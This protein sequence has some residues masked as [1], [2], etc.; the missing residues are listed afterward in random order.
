MNKR[1]LKKLSKSELIKTL[2]KQKKSKKV[3]NHENLLDSDPFKK[4]NKPVKAVDP[5]LPTPIRKRPPKPNRLPPPIPVQNQEFNF[6]DDIFQTENRIL[7]EFK[8]V[9]V[10]NKENKKFKTYTN[11]FKIKVLKELDNSGE[12]YSILKKL[13]NTLKRKRN[14][15]NKIELE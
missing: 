2:L 15:G 9:G 12:M 11:E 13:A 8:I 4:S 3:H 1:D 7:E 5:I 6:D 10:Q 14:L